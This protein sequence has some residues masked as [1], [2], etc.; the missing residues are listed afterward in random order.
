MAT[1]K[2]AVPE[3]TRGKNE[4]VALTVRLPREDWF[5]LHDLANRL[6]QSL[7]ALAVDGFNR[8]LAENG[9]LRIKA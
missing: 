2:T 9:K 1:R 7:Q 3:R 8:I 4:T 5:R 6:G